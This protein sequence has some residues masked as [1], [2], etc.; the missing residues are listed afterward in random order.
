MATV[1]PNV[2]MLTSLLSDKNKEMPPFLFFL[3]ICIPLMVGS[4]LS[5]KAECH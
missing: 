3:P 2:K 1:G 4:I 5:I